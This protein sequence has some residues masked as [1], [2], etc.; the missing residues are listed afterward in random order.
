MSPVVLISTII[1]IWIVTFLVAFIPARL[2]GRWAVG[3]GGGNLFYDVLF[4]AKIAELIVLCVLLVLTL[5]RFSYF[6][7][8]NADPK[9]FG[10]FFLNLLFFVPVFSALMLGFRRARMGFQKKPA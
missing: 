2:I 5:G 6:P 10:F 7:H 4:S 8:L 1:A 3:T 9:G